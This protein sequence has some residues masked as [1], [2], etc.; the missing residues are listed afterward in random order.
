MNTEQQS[1]G[2]TY[3]PEFDFT[4]SVGMGAPTW[5]RRGYD[6]HSCTDAGAASVCGEE[7][8]TELGQTPV[9]GR[10]R[11]RQPPRDIPESKEQRRVCVSRWN[12]HR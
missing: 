5:R 1:Q 11:P 10:S 6:S 4:T 3:Q 8:G 12:D 2:A 7:G 9:G